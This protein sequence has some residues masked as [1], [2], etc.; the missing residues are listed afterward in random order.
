MNYRTVLLLIIWLIACKKKESLPILVIG[1]A[2]MGLEFSGS[3]YHG[4]SEE[5]MDFAIGM[6]NC[7]GV[8]IDV[9]MSS[10]GSLWLSHDETLDYETNSSGCVGDKSIEE[11]N[12]VY[13]NTLKKEKLAE[14][15]EIECFRE[16]SKYLFLDIK[17]ANF[18]Q[19]NSQDVNLFLNG[20]NDWKKKI[21]N[22]SSRVVIVLSNADWVSPFLSAGWNVLFSS[23]DSELRTQLTSAY[24]SLKGFVCKNG[25]CSENDVENLILAGKEI[26]LY[27][28]RSP[29][30]LKQVRKKNPT[31]VL[32]DDVQ[33]SIVEF[34]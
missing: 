33:G 23:D 15:S 10:D 14:L 25:L 20:L 34:K 5:A 3:L 6:P 2:G 24:P 26:Y 13:Y 4:N 27:E 8:E 12:N 28:V 31:G 17:H 22:A 9:R 21:T 30:A 16:G 18:C 29:K 32:S 7:D 1:H 19:N 11:L